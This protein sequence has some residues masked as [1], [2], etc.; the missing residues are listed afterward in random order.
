MTRVL[1][2]E[3]GTSHDEV[4][5]SWYRDLKYMH[6]EVYVACPARVWK[7]LAITD[8][9]D[10]LV[11]EASGGLWRRL[12][13]IL[14][15][16]HYVNRNR[17]THVVLNTASGTTL[18]D[19]S[20]LLPKCCTVIGILH[21]VSK[22]AESSN[23]QIVTRNVDAY[24][25]LAP[26]LLDLVPASFKK[27]VMVVTATAAESQYRASTP[28]DAR[29]RKEATDVPLRVVIAGGI[30]WL[31]RDYDSILTSDGF[32]LMGINVHFVLAGGADPEDRPR[33]A[34]MVDAAPPGMIEVHDD[35]IPHDVYAQMISDADVVLPLTHPSCQDYHF[36]VR[37]R[38]T[39]AMSGAWA[40]GKPLMLERGFEKHVSLADSIFYDVDSLPDMLRRFA[41]DRTL[42]APYAVTPAFATDTARR[43]AVVR[44][45][46]ST[47]SESLRPAL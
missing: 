15:I 13:M 41:D 27:P 37:S 43:S 4:L 14:R 16:R 25:V 20:V 17:I 11:A 29:Y 12:K 34:R 26:Y 33:L 21:D 39:G 44:L 47:S 38:I 19:L 28:D 7:R 36:Y 9:V 30:N 8:A 32:A 10:W 35:Y 5:L 22:I 2:V 18:R 31:R 45:F 3:I 23:Q 42:L 1:I 40:Y 24:A 6:A 46:S